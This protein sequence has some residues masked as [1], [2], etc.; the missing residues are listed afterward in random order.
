MNHLQYATWNTSKCVKLVTCRLLHID[1]F[2]IT[3]KLIFILVQNRV[4]IFLFTGNFL[5][6]NKPNLL[7]CS[8]VF[9]DYE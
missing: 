7:N 8:D 2:M 3:T 5:N 1:N 6:I 4:L 9:N